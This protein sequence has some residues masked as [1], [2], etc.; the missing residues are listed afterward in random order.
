MK[1]DYEYYVATTTSELINMIKEGKIRT[2]CNGIAHFKHLDKRLEERQDEH[3][4]IKY[5]YA[6]TLFKNNQEKS[7]A[8][9]KELIDK[10]HEPS[11]YMYALLNLKG[12]LSDIDKLTSLELMKKSSSLG[13]AV[14]SHGLSFM[15]YNGDFGFEKD[16]EEEHPLEGPP[17]LP[18]QE[19]IEAS[20]SFG[21]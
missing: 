2:N 16:K 10:E 13:Y 6:S 20:K 8:I 12:E 1:Y 21:S 17:P 3:D 9:L 15:Y 7:V 11:M 5:A 14:A 4:N 19:L 18:S